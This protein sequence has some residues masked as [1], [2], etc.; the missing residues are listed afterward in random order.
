MHPTELTGQPWT[1]QDPA[2]ADAQAG[3]MG[4][5]TALERYELGVDPELPVR[6]WPQ[7]ADDLERLVTTM[8]WVGD[9]AAQ[10]ELAPVLLGELHGAYAR[11][12]QRRR[13]VLLGLMRA[14]SRAMRSLNCSVLTGCRPWRPAPCS[15][16]RRPW[17]TQCGWAMPPGGVATPPASS[18]EPRTTGARWPRRRI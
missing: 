11:L 14:Y 15:S 8:T 17:T 5:E 2:G 12:P 4:I 13:E 10:G 9:Y 3:L 18:T 6:P 16:A 1:S 7:I